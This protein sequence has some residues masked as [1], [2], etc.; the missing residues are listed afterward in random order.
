MNKK[1]INMITEASLFTAIYGIFMLFLRS[2][3]GFFES[4]FFFIMPFPMILFSLRHNMKSSFILLISS[5]I[6]GLLISP[7]SMIFYI[8][9]ACILG[10]LYSYFKMKNKSEVLQILITIIGCFFVNLLTMHLFAGVFN[11]DIYDDFGSTINSILKLFDNIFDSQLASNKLKFYIDLL[12]PSIILITSM[13]EGYLMHLVS[14]KLLDK[15][16]YKQRKIIPFFLLQLPIWLGLLSVFFVAIGVFI[17]IFV[18][19]DNGIIFDLSSYC[20]SLSFIGY[21]LLFIQGIA[22]IGCLTLYRN[23]QKWFIL[24]LLLSL[25][26]NILVIIFGI[27]AIFNDKRDKLLYNVRWKE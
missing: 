18:N 25:L 17:F 11:Y 21:S 15:F 2:G 9:P 1:K 26:L 3:G 20:L 4:I 5:A 16:K 14:S 19:E 10:I 27:V 22:F 8:I 12:V 24:I 6:L 7:L 23:M 13:L